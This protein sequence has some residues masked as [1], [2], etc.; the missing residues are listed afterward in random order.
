MQFCQMLSVIAGADRSASNRC[1]PNEIAP[2]ADFLQR[3]I[4]LEIGFQRQRCRDGSASG[5]LHGSVADAGM[6][7][8]KIVI[9]PVNVGHVGDCILVTQNE[10]EKRLLHFDIV[11][12]R[13]RAIAL[14]VVHKFEIASAHPVCSM[15]RTA[16]S[17]SRAHWPGLLHA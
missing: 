7:R 11:R 10:A 12:K 4:A 6:H 15:S 3:T 1:D 9:G 14:P 16:E 17:A 2:A 13:W 8:L 5:H